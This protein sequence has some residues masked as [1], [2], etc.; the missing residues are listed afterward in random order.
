MFYSKT[1]TVAMTAYFYDG[2]ILW[3]THI[4][5]KMPIIK[6]R[7]IVI[8][9]NISFNR[10]ETNQFLHFTQITITNHEPLCYNYQPINKF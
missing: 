5:L 9:V 7:P 6:H 8:I 1:I 4:Q 3:K 2:V 10:Q